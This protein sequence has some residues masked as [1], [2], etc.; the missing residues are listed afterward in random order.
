MALT[1]KLVNIAD[2]VREKLNLSNE[3][4]FYLTD[5]PNAIRNITTKKEDLLLPQNT[6][7][8]I[9]PEL[10]EIYNKVKEVQTEESIT[11]IGLSDFHYPAD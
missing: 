1:E 11:F 3:N 5:I 6:Y 2:A 9:T 4:K 10:I 8:Y 7:D